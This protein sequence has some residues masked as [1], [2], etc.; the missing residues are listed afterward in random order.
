MARGEIHALLGTN[1]CGK[2]TLIKILAA[3]YPAD[4]GTLL[5]NGVEYDLT[6]ADPRDRRQTHLRFVHQQP[7]VFADLTVAENLKMGENVG[8]I[9]FSS[10][11]RRRMRA[12]AAAILDRFEIDVAPDDRLGDLRLALQ[13]MVAIARALHSDEG[14][15]ERV[16]VLDEPTAKLP[17]SETT[18]LFG[19]LRRYA[20][21]GQTILLVTHRMDEVMDLADRAT[22]L[23]D[24]RTVGTIARASFSKDRLTEMI[25]GRSLDA[26]FPEH[27][28]PQEGTPTLRVSGLSGGIV[29]GVDFDVHP[30]EVVG[31]AGLEG[32]GCSTVLRMLFGVE[33]AE[34]GEVSVDGKAVNTS[35]PDK[36]MAAGLAY[37]PADRTVEGIFPDLSVRDNLSLA[38]LGRYGRSF[39]LRRK[40]EVEDAT[41]DVE[42]FQ[43]RGGQDA[44]MNELSGGNQQK[45]V[46]A[47]WLRRK[48][49][50]LLL[51]DPTQGVDIGARADLWTAIDAAVDG[52]AAV[53]VNSSDH[54]E[55]AHVSNRILVMDNGSIAAELTDKGLSGDALSGVLQQA[56]YER[57]A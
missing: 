26:Y 25:V 22:V 10:A 13:T 55:L 11:R 42:R 5:L 39:G 31:L 37:V 57:T 53:L 17:A 28:A 38:T 36:A 15:G 41:A 32:S 20:E 48:P 2:S 51:D 27:T 35:S 19:A 3:V 16:L 12:E 49:R 50:L 21:A 54:D 56:G 43:I 44:M 4:A 30:G 8:G 40:A 18:L 33:P 34:S 45:A 14:S 7:T 23:R 47:R 46:V 24:G 52:G 1:G 6:D 9:N 29:N